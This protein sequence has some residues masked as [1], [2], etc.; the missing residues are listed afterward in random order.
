MFSGTAQVS[1]QVCQ[2]CVSACDDA[3]VVSVGKLRK[4][5]FPE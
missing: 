2:F 4:L 1:V 3:I 5:G